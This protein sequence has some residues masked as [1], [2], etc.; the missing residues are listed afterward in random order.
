MMADQSQNQIQNRIRFSDR[1]LASRPQINGGNVKRIGHV[2]SLV[3]ARILVCIRTSYIV[4]YS[5]NPASRQG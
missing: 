5:L 1:L 2:T 3:L 4:F